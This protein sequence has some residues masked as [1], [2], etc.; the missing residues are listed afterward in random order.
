M[1]TTEIS[2]ELKF[3]Y[4]LK[5]LEAAKYASFILII[6]SFMLIYKMRENPAYI[7]PLLIG[8]ILIIWY[9]LTYLRFKNKIGTK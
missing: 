3:K 1:K 8:V 5:G 2:P 7:L 9:M 6:L 4:L